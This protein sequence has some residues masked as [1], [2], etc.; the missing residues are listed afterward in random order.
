MYAVSAK[1]SIRTAVF[2][3]PGFHHH[4]NVHIRQH[5]VHSIRTHKRVTPV[6]PWAYCA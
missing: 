2:Y 1:V 5:L 6:S 4:H 3:T